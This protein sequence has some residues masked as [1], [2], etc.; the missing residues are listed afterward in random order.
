MLSAIYFRNGWRCIIKSSYTKL[1]TPAK[2]G[3]HFE[4]NLDSGFRRN[5]IHTMKLFFLLAFL[6]PFIVHAQSLPHDGFLR[7]YHSHNDEM[8]EIQYEKDGKI[9]SS[10]M[11]Q[12]NHFLRSRD[13]G[14][15][16]QMDENLI[17]LLDHIQ[18]HFQADAIEVICGYRTPVFNRYLKFIGRNVM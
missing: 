17:R 8:M 3:V 12:I 6:F 9:I 1:V 10:A 5:D 18:D 13:S 7:L 15:S 14:A 2:A 16:A 11:A 4:C